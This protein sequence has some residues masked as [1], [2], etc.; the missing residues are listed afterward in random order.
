MCVC[1]SVCVHT[2]PGEPF[3]R[4]DSQGVGVVIPV[5]FLCA[6]VSLVKLF[7]LSYQH[8]WSVV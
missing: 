8:D 7:L 6:C 2:F 1:L 5:H 4:L 3:S